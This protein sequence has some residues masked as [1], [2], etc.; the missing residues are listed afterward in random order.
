MNLRVGSP[1]GSLTGSIAAP[2]RN[3]HNSALFWAA[4]EERTHLLAICLA[5]GRRRRYNQVI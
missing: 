2:G 3:A 4:S 5:W 1:V